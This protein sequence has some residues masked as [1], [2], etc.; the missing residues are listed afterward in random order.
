MKKFSS[1]HV[2]TIFKF[3]SNITEGLKAETCSSLLPPKA[4]DYQFSHMVLYAVIC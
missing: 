2:R 4:L 3:T 1:F